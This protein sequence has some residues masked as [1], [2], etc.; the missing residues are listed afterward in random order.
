[1]RTRSPSCSEL[2]KSSA[3]RGL[4]EHSSAAFTSSLESR[5]VTINGHRT[6]IRLD[7]ASWT[8]LEEAARR[9]N[10]SISRLCTLISNTKRN[11]GSLTAAIRTWITGYYLAASTE[12]GH[13]LAGHG[14]GEGLFVERSRRF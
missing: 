13:A 8:A 12:E 9:E 2:P 6:S 11:S 5:N 7:P 10:L 4:I 1:M 14:V 3:A